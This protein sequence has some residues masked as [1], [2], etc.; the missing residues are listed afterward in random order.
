MLKGAIGFVP[1]AVDG[2]EAGLVHRSV[3]ARITELADR[4]GC[5]TACRLG[6]LPASFE[7]AVLKGLRRD[8]DQIIAFAD[9]AR[10][11]G[12]M[13]NGLTAAPG[14]KPVQVLETPLGCVWVHQTRGFE[15]RGP[16]GTERITELPEAPGCAAQRVPLPGLIAPLAEA[17]AHARLFEVSAADSAA[18]SP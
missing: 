7:Q 5:R 6:A 15:L 12:W 11:T 13:L 18:G 16:G 2:V 17:A 4:L 1:F 9:A 3:L 8:L 14:D 10:R